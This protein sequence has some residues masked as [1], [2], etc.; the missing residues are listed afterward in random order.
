MSSAATKS[1]ALPH[2]EEFAAFIADGEHHR[3][4]GH[5][6]TLHEAN[7]A[8]TKH[9]GEAGGETTL[10]LAAVL[11]RARHPDLADKMRALAPKGLRPKGWRSAPDTA[12]AKSDEGR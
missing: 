6:M 7:R 5:L 2:E 4:D 12:Q 1:H 9:I 8:F 3:G 11:L 10:G